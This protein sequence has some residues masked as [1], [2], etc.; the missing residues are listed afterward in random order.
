MLRV[1]IRA[2]LYPR[3][4]LFTRWCQQ[5]PKDTLPEDVPFKEEPSKRFKMEGCR[6]VQV[7]PDTVKIVTTPLPRAMRLE[8]ERGTKDL[9]GRKK[10][11]KLKRQKRKAINND[12]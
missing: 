1:L 11:K 9:Q 6:F 10:K 2:H 3:I 8:L 7:S 12:N 4:P 5:L